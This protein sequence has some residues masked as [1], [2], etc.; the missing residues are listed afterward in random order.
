MTHDGR[1]ARG[2]ANF[3]SGKKSLLDNADTLYYLDNKPKDEVKEKKA[4]K[5]KE[6]EE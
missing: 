3:K 5:K 1:I 4:T 6:V 2:E